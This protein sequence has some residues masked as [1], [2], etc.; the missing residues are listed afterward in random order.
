MFGPAFG[1]AQVLAV[2]LGGLVLATGLLQGDPEALL[3]ERLDMDPYDHMDDAVK[4]A[5]TVIGGM[6]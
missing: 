4:A 6:K 3:E 2:G 5:E 1:P